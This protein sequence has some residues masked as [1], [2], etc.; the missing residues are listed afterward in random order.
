M[1]ITLGDVRVNRRNQLRDAAEHTATNLFGRQVAKDAFHQIEPRTT[2]RGEVHVDARVAREPPLNR[3]VF[4]RGVVVGDQMQGLALGD[5]AINQT[6]ERQPFLVP[7]PRQTGGE[8]GALRD[9]EGG[10]ERGGAMAL[11]IVGHRPTPALLHG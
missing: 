7:M 1:R 5:L 3:G 4:V 9:I 10:E 2:R 11:V 8:D 6:K